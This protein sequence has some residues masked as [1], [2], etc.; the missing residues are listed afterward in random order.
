M[1]KYILLAILILILLGIATTVFFMTRGTVIP[2]TIVLEGY[3]ITSRITVINSFEEYI[4]FK[5]ELSKDNFHGDNYDDIVCITERYNSNFIEYTDSFF[6]NNSLAFIFIPAPNVS[7]MLKL[8]IRK[9]SNVIRVN[10]RITQDPMSSP[11]FSRLA[12]SH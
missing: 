2:Y 6:E 1:K 4:L 8:D 3:L 9:H 5:E 10:Y 12:D 11:A 7:D